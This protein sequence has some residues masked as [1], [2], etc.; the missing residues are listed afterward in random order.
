MVRTMLVCPLYTMLHTVG[1]GCRSYIK[2]K[3]HI[4]HAWFNEQFLI[5]L[6]NL[7][8]LT[9]LITGIWIQNMCA[10]RIRIQRPIRSF[11]T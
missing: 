6:N 8:P 1:K 5:I 2:E 3:V 7:G 9:V 4:M 10:V 11:L